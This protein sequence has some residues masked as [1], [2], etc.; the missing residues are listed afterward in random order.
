MDVA[1]DGR[2]IAVSGDQVWWRLGDNWVLL[3]EREEAITGAAGN[4]ETYLLLEGAR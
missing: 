3:Q 2:A 4:G 1:D